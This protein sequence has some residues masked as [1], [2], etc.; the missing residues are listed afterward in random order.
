[1]RSV[2]L[3]HHNFR[4]FSSAHTCDESLGMKSL[5]PRRVNIVIVSKSSNGTSQYSDLSVKPEDFI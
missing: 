3:T 4:F 5:L 1:M 2:E